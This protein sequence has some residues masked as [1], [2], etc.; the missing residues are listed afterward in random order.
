MEAESLPRTVRRRGRALLAEAFA[1]LE[2]GEVPAELVRAVDD[3]ASPR[4]PR[5]PRPPRIGPR[6]PRGAIDRRLVERIWAL[7][8]LGADVERRVERFLAVTGVE[9]H[10][11]PREPRVGE[12]DELE[13]EL[14]EG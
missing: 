10:V 6:L 7:G 13:M 12:G 1:A 9:L 3:L 14:T 2:S 4:A 11:G 8:A 5:I